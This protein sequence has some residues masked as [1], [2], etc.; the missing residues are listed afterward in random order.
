MATTRAYKKAEKSGV[1]YGMDM[2]TPAG[3]LIWNYLDK[4]KKGMKFDDGKEGAP[5]YVTNIVL[6]INDAT[7]AFI[8]VVKEEVGKQLEVFN[9]GEKVKISDPQL[10]KTEDDFDTEKYP[11]LKGKVVIAAN[12]KEARGRPVIVNKAK[13]D[14]SGA[15][16]EG[17]M[18]GRLVIAPY[19]H[20]KGVAYQL[21]IVQVLDD[22]G[23]RF[24]GSSD[25]TAQAKALLDD[26]DEAPAKEEVK[27]ETPAVKGK[28][29]KSS[30][31]DL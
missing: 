10:Y 5:A 12:K 2:K 20:S 1:V 7:K 4:A 28:G 25:Y 19:V 13:E 14:I 31:D 27:E 29:K 26:E 8:K 18:I 9:K 23:T 21:N 15:S 22:D 11:F 6:D 24:G 16:V 17:G 30:L 3:R